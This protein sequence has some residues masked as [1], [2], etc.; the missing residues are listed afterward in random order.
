MSTKPEHHEDEPG[1]LRG[2]VTAFVASLVGAI[3][4]TLVT[5]LIGVVVGAIVGWFSYGS[6]GALIGAVLG[7]VFFAGV[8]VSMKGLPET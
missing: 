6:F 4:G 7:G 5:G 2:L 1:F 8:Y 3:V